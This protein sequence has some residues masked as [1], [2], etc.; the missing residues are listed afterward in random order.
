M[1][2]SRTEGVAHKY[3]DYEDEMEDSSKDEGT[4]D[5]ELQIYNL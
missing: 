5:E 4:E 3:T 1:Q 2:L